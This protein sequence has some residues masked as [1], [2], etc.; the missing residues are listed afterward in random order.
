MLPGEEKNAGNKEFKKI[1][2]Y[3][4]IDSAGIGWRGPRY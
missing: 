1:L 2:P 4:H 3:G